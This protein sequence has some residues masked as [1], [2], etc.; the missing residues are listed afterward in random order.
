MP[1]IISKLKNLWKADGQENVVTPKD[2]KFHFILALDSLVVGEL[3][4]ENGK[5][6]FTYST[7]FK[8]QDKVKPLTEF[9]DVNKRYVSEELYPFFAHRIPGLGQPK[10]KK[11]LKKEKIDETNEAKLLE[12]FGKEVITNPFTLA[13]NSI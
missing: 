10:I 11:I 7:H 12:R 5:W 6:C 2:G 3:I 9:P 4:L 8:M 13:S 1:S